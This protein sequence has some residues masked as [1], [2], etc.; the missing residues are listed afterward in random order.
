M[1]GGLDKVE[2]FMS[3]N[4]LAK[5]IHLWDWQK[6]AAFRILRSLSPNED[7]KVEDCKLHKIYKK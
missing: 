3:A 1:T 5:K 6:K 7:L 4:K 2:I